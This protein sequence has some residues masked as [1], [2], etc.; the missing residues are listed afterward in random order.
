MRTVT[1]S[2]AFIGKGNITLFFADGNSEI[3][4]Q[5]NFR[6][7]DIMDKITAKLSAGEAA[8]IDLEEFS[9]AKKIEEMTNGVVKATE[10]LA[11]DVTLTIGDKTVNGASLSHHIERAALD[12]AKGFTAF[13]KKFSE[14]KRQHTSDE[15]LKF[16][17]TADLPITDD[18]SILGYKILEERP[19][20]APDLVDPHSGKVRQKL[21]SLVFMPDSKVDDNRRVACSTG[22]HIAAR[23]Y[24][25]GFWGSRRRLCLVKIQPKDVIAV[26]LNE[27]S[28]MRVSAYHIVKVLS[29]ADGQAIANGQSIHDLPEAQ[30]MLEEAVAGDHT[31]IIERVE[32]TGLG[33]ITVTKV[34]VKED[35]AKRKQKKVGKVSR[36]ETK[37]DKAK[38]GPKLD[39]K[40]VR[41]LNK[42]IRNK[43]HLKDQ[44]PKYLKKLVQAQRLYDD[45]KSIRAVSDKL[46]L[47]RDALSRNLIKKA[48]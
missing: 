23:S 46:K 38:S 17:E 18:G 34:N 8:T 22:L 20:N 25:S 3:L 40:D 5:E 14:I 37:K 31:P 21:G 45:G 36:I 16:M 39:P 32:V 43:P 30:K 42:L 15:L 27:T 9:I 41:I 7:L 6:T 12:G 48:A 29:L 44:D 33:N 1:I 10:N 4:P 11:G 2:G 28:K 24:I 13:M 47:D 26:P 19:E 35:R